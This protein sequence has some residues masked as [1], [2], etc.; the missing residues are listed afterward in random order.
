MAERD[1]R[2]TRAEFPTLARKTYLNSCSLGALSTRVRAA[3]GKHLDLWEEYGA[4]A[5]YELWLGECAALRG[6]AERLLGAPA[7]SVAIAPSVG[8]ALSTIASALDYSA[9][10]K[11]VTTELDFPTLPYQW[12]AR[13]GVEVEVLASDDGVSVPLERFAV[14]IDERTALVATTH[15]LFASGTIQPIAEIARLARQAGALILVDGYQAAGQVPVDVLASDVDFYLTGGLKWLLGGTG[16]VE[17]YVRPELIA[18][19]EPEVTGWFAHR[20]QFAFDPRHFA[21][22]DDARRF[23][24]GTPSLAAVYAGRAGIE[25]ILEHGPE[26][27]RARQLELVADLVGRLRGSGAQLSIIDDL[28]QHAG[29]VMLRSKDPKRVVRELADAGIIVDTRPGHVRISPYFYNL[30]DDHQVLIEALERRSLLD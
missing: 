15:V 24:I 12:L 7:G 9:R 1:W 18:S 13:H 11:I 3:I 20:D 10:P 2:Q 28:Q 14:A 19:L 4:S 23:E 5:W 8:V 26:A 21:F 30:P 6:A 27:I 29:I 22:A 25:I 16:I 17:V